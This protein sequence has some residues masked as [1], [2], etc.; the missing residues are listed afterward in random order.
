MAGLVKEYE[1]DQRQVSL[2]DEPESK[3]R[4]TI[5]TKEADE[6]VS[7]IHSRMPL[8]IDRDGVLAWL[9]GVSLAAV[10]SR[11]AVKLKAEEA[12]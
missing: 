5:L 10:L 7:L 2:F 4:F 8:I 6:V 12:V 11:Q 9:S 3:L 1:E